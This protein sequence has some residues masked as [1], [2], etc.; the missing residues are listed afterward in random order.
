MATDPEI[1]ESNEVDLSDTNT[2]RRSSIECLKRTREQQEKSATEEKEELI[3]WQKTR[4]TNGQHRPLLIRLMTESG[5]EQSQHNRDFRKQ[6]Y[7]DV[8]IQDIKIALLEE[9]KRT[10]T[11]NAAITGGGAGLTIAGLV[12][13]AQV[14]FGG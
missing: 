1:T 6:M 5:K 4:Q 14:C 7:Q 8:K 10:Q 9:W 3:E 13:L 11:R 2:F 12:K